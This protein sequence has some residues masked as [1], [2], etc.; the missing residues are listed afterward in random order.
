MR[1]L[2]FRSFLA[3]ACSFLWGLIIPAIPLKAEEN[4]QDALPS[5]LELLYGER[6]IL[7]KS[8]EPLITIGLLN[9]KESI[10][11]SAEKEPLLLEWY[12]GEVYRRLEMAPGTTL[13]TTILKS[14]PADISYFV[15]L[16][17]DECQEAAKNIIESRWPGRLLLESGTILGSRDLTVDTRGHTTVIRA[18]SLPEG[19]KLA[20]ALKK[21]TSLEHPLIQRLTRLPFGEISLNTSLGAPLGQATGYIRLTP[22]NGGQIAFFERGPEEKGR[23]KM[24][25]AGTI[26]IVINS[27]G[28]L[29]AVNVLGLETLL[30]G[31]VPAEIFPSAPLEALKAQAI[32]ARS[33]I[34]AEL[35]TRHFLDPFHIC[36]HE[37]CQVYGGVNKRRAETDRAIA[38]T[39]GMVLMHAGKLVNALY[40]STCGGHSEANWAAWPQNPL[41]YLVAAPDWPPAYKSLVADLRKEAA[42]KEFILRD[43]PA[44]CRPEKHKPGKNNHYR[45]QKSFSARELDALV[46][47]F[48]PEL[49]HITDIKV[50]KRGPGGRVMELE[51]SAAGKKRIIGPELTIRRLFGNL[52]SAFFFLEK[53]GQNGAERWV[54]TGAG[55]GHGVGL[56][57]M[58]AIGRAKSGATFKEILEH[59]YQGAKV[60]KLY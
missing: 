24:N 20:A 54:F 55:W 45:W 51:L 8:G 19:E 10:T 14:R 30:E 57:Q 34:V 39:R 21:I 1:R 53:E 44:F 46:Q 15:D 48:Y 35:G 38:E 43:E 5:G 9:D 59:Y 31:L 56:C 18:S 25:Y 22:L 6:V 33:N 7:Q 28:K 52:K 37:H 3:A 11:F 17:L 12:E 26:Y 60:T 2:F 27:G 13:K 36:S 29:A 47:A 4:Q 40:S 23:S 41:P 42:V 49:G 32:A 58:G 50:L 16:R